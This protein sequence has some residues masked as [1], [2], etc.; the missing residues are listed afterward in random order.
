MIVA[1]VSS[2]ALLKTVLNAVPDISPIPGIC[3]STCGA[4][5]K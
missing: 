5:T 2:S 4:T 3:I 1:K